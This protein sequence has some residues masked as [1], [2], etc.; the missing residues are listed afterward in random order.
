MDDKIALF[1]I[2]TLILVIFAAAYTKKRY[3][4]AEEGDISIFGRYENISLLK[5][6]FFKL[7]FMTLIPG[8]LLSNQKNV[9]LIVRALIAGT[10]VAFYH[11]ALQPL[12]NFIPPL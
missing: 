1:F 2:A 5:H 12:I 7:F 11:V 10:T 3:E 9:P 4:I 6:D 8:Y